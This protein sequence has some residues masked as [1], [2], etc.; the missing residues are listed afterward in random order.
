MKNIANVLSGVS[1]RGAEGGSARFVRLSDLSDI[2]AGR[3]PALAAGDVPA[4]AR[5]LTVEDGDLIVGARG[6]ATDVCVA[7]D[8]VFGAFVS[9]DLYLVRPDQALIN[10]QYLSAFLE[11]SATQAMLAGGKQGSSLA[12][13]PK[14]ALEGM[15]VPIPPLHSQ[16]LIAGL[17]LAFEEEG[18]LLKKLA[19]LRSILVRESIARAIRVAD[20]GRNSIRS[21]V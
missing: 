11:L 15:Q 14:S 16:R 20:T 4:V 6:A 9:L 1:V 17:A 3:R 13:L 10:P 7:N 19:D 18:K 5:A 2:K 21:P 12:R 8:A